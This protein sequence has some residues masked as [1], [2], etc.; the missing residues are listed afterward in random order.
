MTVFLL[1][2]SLNVASQDNYYWSE[3]YGTRAS[4]LGGAATSG[5]G[6]V[7]TLYYNPAAMSFVSKP[8]LSITVNA[9]QFK[10]VKLHNAAGDGLDL[11]NTQFS[12]FPNFIGGMVKF[13]KFPRFR[14]GYAMLAKNNF[15]SK[16]DILHQE[17]YE[18]IDTAQGLERYIASY[19]LDYSINEYMGGWALSF[20]L[21]DTWSVGFANFGTYR[22]V[23]YANNIDVNIFPQTYSVSSIIYVGSQVD[24]DYYTIK[25]V[26]KPSIALDAKN[27]KFGMAYTTPSIHIMGSGNVYRKVSLLNVEFSPGVFSSVSLVDNRRGVN[28]IH[29]ENGAFAIGISWRFK[30]RAWLHFT[31]ETFYGN[32]Y[33]LLFDPENEVNAYPDA[34]FSPDTVYRWFGEQNYLAYGEQSINLTNF[35]LGFETKIGER[36]ELLLGI[37]TDVINSGSVS[38][39]VIGRIGTEGSKWWLLHYS[40]GFSRVSKKGKK[41]TVGL[42]YGMATS[43]N[44]YQFVNFTEPTTGKLYYLNIEKT[45]YASQYSFEIVIGIE[46]HA[47][48]GFT[49]EE[50]P[51]E[52]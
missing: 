29:K 40:L 50:I 13:K 37:R 33:Y 4:L 42:E 11:K 35:G 19:S 32:N 34:Y 44:F 7:A 27:F 22:S 30:K 10:S 41:V 25:T 31:H 49:S 5:L 23:K 38:T 39:H 15:R 36:W 51:V 3:Q 47:A 43:N 16:F 12:T 2:A 17:D 21:S 24:F 8:S 45:A 20:K 26:F 48:K 28:V 18:L 46:L 14:V 52:P 9:Y 6:D 1:L